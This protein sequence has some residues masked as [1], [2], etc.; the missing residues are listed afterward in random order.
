MPEG[1]PDVDGCARCEECGILAGEGY[2]T[3]ELIGGIWPACFGWHAR[4][5]AE[6]PWEGMPVDELHAI[7]RR[8]GYRV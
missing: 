3:R 5:A 8:A 7:A 6:H 2:L 4:K 1:W